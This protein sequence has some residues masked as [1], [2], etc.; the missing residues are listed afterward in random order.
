[1]G[2]PADLIT[3]PTSVYLV[4]VNTT[5]SLSPPVGVDPRPVMERAGHGAWTVAGSRCARCARAVAYRW[6][7][8]PGCAGE[9][10]P[11][12]FGDTGT[13]WSRTVVNIAVGAHV[14]PYEIAYVDLDDGPRVLAHVTGNPVAI[15]AAVRLVEPSA[16]G[17][18]SVEAVHR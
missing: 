17:D 4:I 16:D 13:V 7:R 14:P 3:S 1:M 10:V 2:D 12:N 11:E 15:G 9:L 6:A 8:C 18:L 5:Q